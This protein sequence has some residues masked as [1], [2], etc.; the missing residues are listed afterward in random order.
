MR[1]AGTHQ[2]AYWQEDMFESWPVIAKGLGFDEGEARA[3][4]E[5]AKADY[6]E[7]NPGMGAEGST[8]VSSLL[9]VFDAVEQ[10]LTNPTG[11]GE[12]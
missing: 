10:E 12:Q 7:D 5:K 4:T 6:L 8:P 9:P 11:D 2:W 3:Q 1:N